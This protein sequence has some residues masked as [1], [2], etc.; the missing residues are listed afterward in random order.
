MHVFSFKNPN[1]SD[2]WQ[3]FPALERTTASLVVSGT[4]VPVGSGLLGAFRDGKVYL[5]WM[6]KDVAPTPNGV[7]GLYSIRLVRLPLKSLATKPTASVKAAD[8]FLYRNFGRNAAQDDPDDLVSYERPE[9]TVNSDGHIVIVYGR[10][11]YQ[12]KVDLFP[13][14]RYSVYYDDERGLRPSRLLHVGEYMPMEVKSG[15]TDQTIETPNDQLDHQFATVDPVDERRVWMISEYAR[16][17][18]SPDETD[19]YR[20]VVGRVTP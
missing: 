4:K 17:A 11:G 15:E 14:A 20:T 5:V 12:T 10:V 13:E 18:K 19:D 3:K 9:I 1:P 6:K 7:N 16:K 2:D 8:G